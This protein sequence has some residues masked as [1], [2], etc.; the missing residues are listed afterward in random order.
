MNDTGDRA[1]VDTDRPEL[2]ERI[3]LARRRFTQMA[4]SADPNA[5]VPGREWT[6]Q[7]VVAHVLTVAHRYQAVAEDRDFHRAA[8]PRHLDVVNRT[9]LEAV[10]APVAELL[11]QL[12]ALAPVM[13]GLFDALPHDYAVE[14]HFGAVVSGTMAQTNWLSELLFHGQDIAHAMNVPW[15]LNERD[16]LLIARGVTEVCPS[17]LRSDVSPDVHV[18][19][20][21]KV[22]GARQFVLSIQNGTAE[23]RERRP[24]DRPDASLRVPASTLIQMLYSRIGPL[25]AA[26]KG[27]MVVGGRRPWVALKLMSYFEE[28]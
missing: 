27:L 22:P 24:S 14:F 12:D 2:R 28:P 18:C 25:T 4:Y 13:D 11:D 1:I 19:V 9:E 5:R 16:M 15:E 6:V 26:R 8:N 10:M 17:F 23:M 21:F 20:A 7:Q 3:S